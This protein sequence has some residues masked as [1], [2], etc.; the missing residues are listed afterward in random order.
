MGNLGDFRQ[1]AQARVVC[2]RCCL[3]MSRGLGGTKQTPP[4]T[5]RC[6]G[7]CILGR[8]R[9]DVPAEPNGC[10]IGR[11]HCIVRGDPLENVQ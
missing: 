7:S 3:E 6:N 8:W 1:A 5:P 10:R 11:Q 9:P 4:S 2:Q